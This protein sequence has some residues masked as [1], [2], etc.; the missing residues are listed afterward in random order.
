MFRLL[1]RGQVSTPDPVVKVIELW[2]K[3]VEQAHP[4]PFQRVRCRFQACPDLGSSAT[5]RDDGKGLALGGW[6]AQG[7]WE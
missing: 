4:G 6:R 2:G 5:V 1:P 3:T 7:S